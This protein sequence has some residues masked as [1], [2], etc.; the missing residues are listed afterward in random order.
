MPVVILRLAE[1]AERVGITTKE[2]IHLVHERQIRYV[3]VDGIARL[4]S[5][6]CRTT[7]SRSAGGPVP[8]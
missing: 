4:P 8:G 7:V 5:D 6:D 2:R 1:A 3:L